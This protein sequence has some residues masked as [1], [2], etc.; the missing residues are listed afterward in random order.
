MRKLLFLLFLTNTALFVNAQTKVETSELTDLYKSTT[1]KQISIHD[2]SVVYDANTQYFYIYG[3]HYFGGKSKDL[4]NW[5]PITNYYNTTYDKAF[6]SNAKRTVKRVLPGKTA[7]DAESV[8]FPSYDAAAFCAT[9]AG[10]TVGDRKPTTEAQ[11][12]SG[13]QWAADVVWN[14]SMNK[15]CYYVSLNGDYWASVVVLMTSDKPEG[16]Y[17]YQGPV[18]FGGFDGQKHSGKAVD[19]KTTDLE[20]VLGT[21]STLPSRYKTDKWGTFYPNCID[22]CVFFD[23]EGEMWLAYGS[24]SG[25]IW[26]LK[27][28]KETGLRD[29]TYTYSGTGTTPNATSDDAYFG[30]RIAGGYYVSGEGPY[31]QRIGDY[32][33]LFMSYGFFSP[34]G[35]YEMRVFRSDKP[36]GPYKD[37]SGNVAT[38]TQY[39]MNYGPKAQTNKGMKLIGAMNH[40]GN[41]TVG[42]CA[43]G[44]NSACVDDKGR[45]FLVCHTKYNNGTA[46]HNVRAYQMYLNKS[47]W[48]VTAPFQFNG[49]TTTDADIASSRPWSEEDVAGEYH[50]LIHPYKLD[51]ENMQEV[52]PKTITL[53]SDGKVRGDY[54]GSWKYTDEGKSYFEI[55]LTVSGT[56][57]TYYGVVVEQ[58][59]ENNTAKTLC[60][61]AVANSGVPVWGYKLQPKSAIAY[62]YQQHT[63]AFKLTTLSSVSK[64]INIMFDPVENVDLSWTSSNPELL[65]ETGK[66]NPSQEDETV[67]MKARLSSGNYYWE[68]EYSSKV[69]AAAEVKGDPC[70]GIVA[71]YDFDDSPNANAYNAEQQVTVGRSKTT[72]TA[73]KYEVDY[74]RFGNVLHTYFGAQSANS[75]ARMINPLKG[76]ANLDGF[77]VSMWVNR[78]DNNLF[79]ALWSFFSPTSPAAEGARLYFTGNCYIGFNDNAGH[80]FDVNHPDAKKPT[81]ITVGEWR[82]V[83]VTFSKE[84]GYALYVD[85]SKIYSTSYTDNAGGTIDSFDKQ[86]VL[87]HVTSADYF[88]LGFGSFWG[89]ADAKYDDLLIYNRALSSD[90][91]KGLTTLLNRTSDFTPEGVS[92]E[93]VETE[94]AKPAARQGIYDLT[95]RKV[96][97]PAAHGIYIVNGKKVRY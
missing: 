57:T 27:L 61:T 25:G 21:Q 85:G 68:N 2:P 96:A 46:G 55:K 82:L 63:S 17:T 7:A 49:E 48:L 95:G 92:I 70:T 79:D 86:V 67:T 30:K 39:Q 44:H 24:W 60:F 78:T 80:W 9:Y 4:R 14:P 36:T 58:T 74:Q 87:N 65:S 37:A 16:P 73:P 56:S 84:D 51:Y 12:V 93:T 47:G 75:Y 18:V 72:T 8:D 42:E 53:T 77:T 81:N 13:D 10:V 34:D 22:P 97:V 83:T 91:V 66:Y 5:S 31:I 3:S 54:S 52:T 89:S 45:T 43:Q 62:N 19:Y 6:K 33:Y 38:Y 23:K 15:W 35:G 88:Y 59:L 20:I 41:M 50:V 28:D 11:W 40:W 71:Y 1:S 26:M 32:Y 94:A 69:K 76:A 64:N 90:D 29:Y